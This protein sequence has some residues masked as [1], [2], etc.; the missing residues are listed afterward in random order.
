VVVV[1][2]YYNIFITVIIAAE[3]KES[4]EMQCQ[5][6]FTIIIMLPHCYYC[7]WHNFTVEI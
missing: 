6:Y 5:K 3:V 2:S 7:L 1:Y 4:K